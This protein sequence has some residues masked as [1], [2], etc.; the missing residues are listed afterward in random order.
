[1]QPAIRVLRDEL[2]SIYSTM[3]YYM[4]V[5]YK[6]TTNTLLIQMDLKDIICK[7]DVDFGNVYTSKNRISYAYVRNMTGLYS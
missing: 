1:M 2:N 7:G 5:N 6:I 3:D 4:Q